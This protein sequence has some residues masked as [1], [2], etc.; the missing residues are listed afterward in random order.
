MG[1]RRFPPSFAT[2][3]HCGDAFQ[4]RTDSRNVYCSRS[5]VGLSKGWPQAFVKEVRGMWDKGWSI[6][7]IARECGVSRDVIAGINYRNDFPTR[8]DPI[9]RS[10]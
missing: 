1:R 7:H 9:R 2:C 5:C 8:P 4:M 3:Q 10:A 6:N